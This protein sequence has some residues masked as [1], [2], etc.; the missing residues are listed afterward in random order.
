LPNR[1]DK[2]PERHG[3]NGDKGG[4]AIHRYGSSEDEASVLSRSETRG[5]GR[6][7]APF[8]QLTKKTAVAQMQTDCKCQSQMQINRTCDERT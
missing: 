5:Q 1:G 2:G 4:L 3:D 7:R 8:G 6:F